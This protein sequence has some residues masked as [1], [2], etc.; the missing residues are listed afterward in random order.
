[1]KPQ[2]TDFETDAEY[3]EALEK[4]I[5]TKATLATFCG[6]VELFERLDKFCKDRKIKKSRFVCEAITEKLKSYE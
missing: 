1:M 5:K 3:I 2:R 4:A 6:P